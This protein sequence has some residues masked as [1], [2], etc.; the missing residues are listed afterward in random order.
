MLC[1]PDNFDPRDLRTK[2]PAVA[3]IALVLGL[4]AC[5]AQERATGSGP[6][7]T[8]GG[9]APGETIHLVGTE[10]FWGGQVSGTS[11]RYT[12]PDDP[13]GTSFKVSRFAGNNGLGFSGSF[14]G[15]DFDLA[16]T[17]GTCVDGMSERSYPFVATL[18]IGNE[19]RDGCAWTDR[20]GVTEQDK[21]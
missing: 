21:S 12:T 16:I 14:K 8:F 20:Q 7:G 10:P 1:R 15:K 4:A 17:P 6:G 5:Q 11:V 2:L 19:Q 3:V 9:I 18:R 13:N